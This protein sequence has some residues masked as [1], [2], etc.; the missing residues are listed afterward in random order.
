MMQTF[1]SACGK[2]VY[3]N[4]HLRVSVLTVLWGCSV[5]HLS[6]LHRGAARTAELEE[7]FGPKWFKAK[8]SFRARE[9]SQALIC[10][11]SHQ[12]MQISRTRSSLESDPLA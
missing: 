1:C 10:F 11:F 8:N 2:D 3:R 4:L 7:A 6:F 5:A 12:S 9:G